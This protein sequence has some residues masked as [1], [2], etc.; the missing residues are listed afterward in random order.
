[1]T[2]DVER[3]LYPADTVIFREGDVGE[4]VFIT[5][6]GVVEITKVI[7]GN[8]VTLGA[9]TDNDIFGE[10]TSLEEGPR[11]ATA[12][13]VKE[14]VCLVVPESEIRARLDHSDPFT[15]AMIRILVKNIR[16]VTTWIVA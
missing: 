7:N 16:T 9:L 11:M 13:A 4:R 6:T 5:E 2:G 1:M 8:E 10:L 14:T 3:V 12:T 15:Q